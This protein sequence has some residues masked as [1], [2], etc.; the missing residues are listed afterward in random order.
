MPPKIVLASSSPSRLRLLNNAGIKPE[1]VVSGVDEEDSAYSKLTPSELVIALAIVK[2]HTVRKTIN[3][4]ALIIGCDSTFEFEGESLGKPIT[5]ENA[6]A[7]AK[8]LRGK[9]GLLHTGHCIID[10]EKGIEISDIA[11]TRVFFAEMTDEE[12]VSYVATGEPLNVAGGF[13]L[14]GLSSPFIAKIEGET[15][16][17]IGLSLPLLRN[18][19]NK[20]GYRWF[21]LLS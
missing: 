6:I 14:D 3:Y 15:S 16:N 12:I 7:R 4:P 21:D 2:A 11:T 19:V 10:T 8:L 9:S 18:A 20:L 13:T 5:A 17:V 1:V